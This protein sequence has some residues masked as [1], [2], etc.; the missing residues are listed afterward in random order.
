MGQDA[1]TAGT[2]R[3]VDDIR[4]SG[5]CALGNNVRKAFAE[6]VPGRAARNAGN[7]FI[8]ADDTALAI[9]HDEADVDSVKH[10]AEHEIGCVIQHDR[11]V[12]FRYR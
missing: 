1:R 6:H 9:E 12:A 2:K 3:I 10:R 11:R 5:V 7:P 4:Q 8:P